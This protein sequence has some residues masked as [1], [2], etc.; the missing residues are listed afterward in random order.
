M[1]MC[2]SIVSY[3]SVNTSGCFILSKK[4]M[5]RKMRCLSMDFLYIFFLFSFFHQATTSDLDRR[6]VETS[7]GER[8]PPPPPTG[9]RDTTWRGV[10]TATP[11]PSCRNIAG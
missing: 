9:T 2:S 1:F 7:P 6:E 11:D 5:L 10:T 8:T 4:F 3:L